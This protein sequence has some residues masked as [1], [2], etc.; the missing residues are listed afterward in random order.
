[1]TLGEKLSLMRKNS[2]FT[3]EEIANH[4]GV[5]P[6]AVSKW[7]ND[8]SCPDIMLLPKIAELYGKTIDE[9]LDEGETAQMPAADNAQKKSKWNLF[10]HS[11][12]MSKKNSTGRF[13]KVN[14]LSRQ[15]DN[16]HVKLP[17]ALVKSLKS[18][19]KGIKVNGDI[20]VDLNGIDFDMVFELVDSGIMGEIVNVDTSNGDKIRVYVEA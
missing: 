3:Q 15:G 6:Q 12:T 19:L 17:V 1:M 11:D 14:V 18:I 2:S 5:S 20:G 7:E 16:I 8:L 9:L 10:K 4:L 13:L